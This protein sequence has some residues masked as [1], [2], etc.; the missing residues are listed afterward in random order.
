MTVN[1]PSFQVNYQGSTANALIT[2][3]ND[4]SDTAETAYKAA[5]SDLGVIKEKLT[6]SAQFGPLIDNI[7]TTETDEVGKVVTSLKNMVSGIQNIGVSW[8]GVSAEIHDALANY[9]N[10]QG[11]NNNGGNNA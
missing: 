11:N 9:T 6:G 7:Q 4:A 5:I 10:Q 8:Q 1:D 3:I 2:Q